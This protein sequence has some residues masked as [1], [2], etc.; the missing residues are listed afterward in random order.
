MTTFLKL[1]PALFAAAPLVMAPFTGEIQTWMAA[2]PNATS[3]LY[4]LAALIATFV[5]P[6]VV[7]G[8][9]G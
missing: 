9:K 2:N 6:P 1:I 4:A 7:T 3:A 5:K 8:S